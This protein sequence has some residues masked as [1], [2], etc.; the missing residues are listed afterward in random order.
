MKGGYTTFSQYGNR[1]TKSALQPDGK[2]LLESS[3]GYVIRIDPTGEQ[4]AGFQNNVHHTDLRGIRLTQSGRVLLFGKDFNKFTPNQPKRSGIAF[5]NSSGSLNTAFQNILINGS[6]ITDA[7]ILNDGKILLAGTILLNDADTLHRF[8]LLRLLPDGSID[9][10]FQRVVFDKRINAIQLLPNGKIL[11]GGEFTKADFQ[12][13]KPILLLN[14]NGTR[15]PSFSTNF[16][17]TGVFRIIP[18]PNGRFLLVTPSNTIIQMEPSG[19]VNNSFQTIPYISDR[20]HSPIE[21]LADG[22][23]LVGSGSVSFDDSY[24]RKYSG[25]GAKD[26]SLRINLPARTYLTS[27]LI[28]P[29][30][31]ILVA[32]SFRW[33]QNELR[34]QLALFS[35]SGHLLSGYSTLPKAVSFVNSVAVQ[36]DQ[37]I[38]IGGDFLSVWAKRQHYLARLLPDGELDSTFQSNIPIDN[39]PV[40]KVKIQNDGKILV[41][42]DYGSASAGETDWSYYKL[43][44]YLKNGIRDSSFLSYF[45]PDWKHFNH[46]EIQPNEKILMT[47]AFDS[48]FHKSRRGMIRL[49]PDGTI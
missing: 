26:T 49:F 8:S 23:I 18:C 47:G 20:I 30:N 31:R 12:P 48:L 15:D 34:N 24:V 14:E 6:L 13:T 44:R 41:L 25:N 42:R 21:L 36:E 35:S 38:V 45:P 2:V 39:H 11:A 33:I 1:Y 40:S 37:K 22:T 32:G 43:E 7:E 46:I 29:E 16:N 19:L 17:E 28:L 5:L 4:D 27:I 10:G 9:P 3:S